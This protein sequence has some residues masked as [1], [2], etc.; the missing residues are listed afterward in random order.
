MESFFH[1]LKLECTDDIQFDNRK[2]AMNNILTMC[3]FFIIIKECIYIWD[4][5][6]LMHLKCSL[7]LVDN[8]T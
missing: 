7:E 6:H 1:T 8:S 2:E 3:K 5:Y 4:I